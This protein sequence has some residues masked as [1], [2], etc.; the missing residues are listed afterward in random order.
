ML[1]SAGMRYQHEYDIL[2]LPRRNQLVVKSL[3]GA[4]LTLDKQT[5]DAEMAE[6]VKTA[7][8]ELGKVRKNSSKSLAPLPPY[9]ASLLYLGCNFCH[10]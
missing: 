4:G 7:R 6:V 1:S 2:A 5:V 8:R 10:C 3:K 9:C